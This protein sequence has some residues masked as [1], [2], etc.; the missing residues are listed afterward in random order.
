MY[1]SRV[2]RAYRPCLK[3]TSKRLVP[4]LNLVSKYCNVLLSGNKNLQAMFEIHLEKIGS[5]LKLGELILDS[6]V[7]KLYLLERLALKNS[8]MWKKLSL[9]FQLRNRSIF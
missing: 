1:F 2:T 3:S 5:Y 9:F 8:N 4:R 7:R 6:P